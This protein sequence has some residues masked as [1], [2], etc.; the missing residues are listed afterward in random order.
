MSI[1]RI[2]LLMLHKEYTL[3][4]LI[5][6]RGIK[7]LNVSFWERSFKSRRAPVSFVMSVHLSAHIY[8]GGSHW[9]GFR[10]VLYWRFT[11]ICQENPNLVQVG[12]KFRGISM[13]I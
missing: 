5:I 2:N 4:I 13:K 12:Q 6:I 9:T 7:L 8:Q 3:F 1:F 10:N 11:E